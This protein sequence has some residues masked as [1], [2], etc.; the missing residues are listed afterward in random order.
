MAVTQKSSPILLTLPKEV[1]LRIYEYIFVDSEIFLDRLSRHGKKWSL[2]YDQ[3]IGKFRKHD[4]NILLS[5][6]TIWVEGIQSI[7]TARLKQCSDAT[8]I[9]HTDEQLCDL[10]LSEAQ[11]LQ[12]KHLITTCTRAKCFKAIIQNQ[13]F[14]SLQ[15]IEWR[16]S[17]RFSPPCIN[18][19]LPTGATVLRSV[20]LETQRRTQRYRM[21]VWRDR[22][23][24]VKTEDSDRPLRIT[25]KPC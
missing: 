8:N 7:Q 12:L 9:F 5:C 24:D 21:P 19:C 22:L 17:I 23:Y 14:N 11:D 16:T 3:G 13:P 2:R 25:I 4:L 6:R 15:S 10:L 1:R 20:V 18:D